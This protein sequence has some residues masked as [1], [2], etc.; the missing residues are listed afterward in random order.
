MCRLASSL[1]CLHG[2]LEGMGGWSTDGRCVPHAPVSVLRD[3][4][5]AVRACAHFYRLSPIYQSIS[6]PFLQQKEALPPHGAHC[7]ESDLELLL[8]PASCSGAAHEDDGATLSSSLHLV[9]LAGSEN[10]RHT[11]AAGERLREAGASTWENALFH[12]GVC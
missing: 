8:L 2:R 10:V 6:L 11:G 7:V 4:R 1:P 5:Q 3:A 9:D 12:T